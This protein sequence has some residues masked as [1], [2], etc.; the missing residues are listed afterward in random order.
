MPRNYDRIALTDD[1]R[2]EL[3]ENADVIRFA[4]VDEGGLPHVVPV[5]FAEV[6]GQICFE[7]DR[8][9][10]KTRN[11][12][13][14]GTAAAVVD[15]GAD[16]YIEHRGIQWRGDARIVEDAEFEAEIERALFGTVKSVPGTERHERVKI[17]LAPRR[18]VSWDFRQ[19][20]E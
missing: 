11:V 6:D 2:A 16:E 9:S 15:A 14:T 17:A 18:E 5:A 3:I 7:T 10:V 8:D 13:R 12:E 20:V 19:L 1:A 4:T